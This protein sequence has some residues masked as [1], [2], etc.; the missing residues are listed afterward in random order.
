[1]S[2]VTAVASGVDYYRKFN[3]VLTQTARV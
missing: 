3:H 1:V 2:V